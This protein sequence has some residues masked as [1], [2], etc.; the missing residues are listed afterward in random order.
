[1]SGARYELG[2]ECSNPA[3]GSGVALARRVD[4]ELEFAGER[5]LPQ[6]AS[7]TDALVRTIDAL[8]REMGVTPAM[9][10]RVAVS[11]G[12]GGY[13]ALRTSVAAASAIARALACEPVG[14]P[15]HRVAAH[16]LDESDLPAMVILASK[17]QRAHASVVARDRSVRELG[18]VDASVVEGLGVATLV[19]DAHAPAVFLDAAR[20]AGVRAVPL[21][22]DAWSCLRAAE[23]LE[24]VDPADL[25][26]RYAREPDAVTQWRA[27]RADRGSHE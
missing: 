20:A 12:P 5:E 6:G 25:G 10:A 24:G 14:V 18:V 7:G 2:I 23:G 9:L 8:T 26:V 19:G 4:G 13:T 1:V 21:A 17:A 3:S 16:A 11:V 15:T 27:R 22:L